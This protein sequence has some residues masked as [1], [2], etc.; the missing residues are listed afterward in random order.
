M[1]YNYLQ[2]FKLD[3]T[4]NHLEDV[5]QS[6]FKNHPE[7]NAG[8]AKINFYNI[9]WN[10]LSNDGKQYYYFPSTDILTN[11]DAIIKKKSE[12]EMLMKPFLI[13][14]DKMVKLKYFKNYNEKVNDEL[15]AEKK[16]FNAKILYQDK[17]SLLV[18]TK[19]N[20][21]DKSPSFLQSISINTGKTLW[22]LPGEIINYEGGGKCK[23]GFAI[24]YY[25]TAQTEY[26]HGVCIIS[27]TG[28]LLYDYRISGAD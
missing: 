16:Y 4:K 8:I 21:N 7:L 26:F 24:Y 22:T 9:Y 14:N 15:N 1:T 23:E 3:R 6:Q 25:S 18:T 10:I 5:T 17:T 27:T 11:D 2:L 13:E 12:D 19:Q 28:K 20:A